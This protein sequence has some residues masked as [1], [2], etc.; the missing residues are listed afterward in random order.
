[1]VFGA[2]MLL[3]L[4]QFDGAESTSQLRSVSR[5]YDRSSRIHLLDIILVECLD[6]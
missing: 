2:D 5:N 4:S 1:M 6:E 3:P